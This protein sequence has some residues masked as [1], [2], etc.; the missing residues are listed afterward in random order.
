[1]VMAGGIGHDIDDS[2][3]W[4]EFFHADQS[5]PTAFHWLVILD[6]SRQPL[7]L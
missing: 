6:T 2:Y 3:H 7:Y 5:N 4:L 1:M